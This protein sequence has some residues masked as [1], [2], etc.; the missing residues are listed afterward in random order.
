MTEL[1]EEQ[2]HSKKYGCNGRCCDCQRIDICPETRVHEFFGTV[3][4]V[5][6]LALSP[7]VIIAAIILMIWW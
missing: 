2:K 4:A 7:I 3:G 5:L 1:N 6:I